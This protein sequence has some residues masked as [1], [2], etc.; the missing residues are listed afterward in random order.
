MD[1]R[2]CPH[3]HSVL[4][5]WIGPPESG[6]GELFV[7]NN[8][9]CQYYLTSNTCLVEQGGKDCLGFRYAEDPMNNYSSFNLLSWFPASLKEKAQA[10]M[11]AGKG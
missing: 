6:W 8:N 4:E 10:L 5:S 1:Q 11:E 2:T 9:D 3:C 7:C